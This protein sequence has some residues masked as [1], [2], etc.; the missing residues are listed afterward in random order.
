MVRC[1]RDL[2]WSAK[3]QCAILDQMEIAKKVYIKGA[4]AA[5][6]LENLQKVADEKYHGNFSEMVNDSLNRL[7]HLDPDTGNPLSGKVRRK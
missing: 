3:R 4:A 7:H 2:I 6:R 1:P 5:E